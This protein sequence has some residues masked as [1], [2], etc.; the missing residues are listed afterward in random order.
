MYYLKLD[1]DTSRS[2]DF[3]FRVYLYICIKLKKWY[4]LVIESRPPPP[5]GYGG[6]GGGWK[7]GGSATLARSGK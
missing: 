4:T 2:S 6:G 3:L 1:P 5:L 7:K